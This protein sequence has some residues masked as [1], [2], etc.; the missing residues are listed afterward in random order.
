MHVVACCLMASA[1]LL[2]GCQLGPADRSP[3]GDA[4]PTPQ[5]GSVTPSDELS[6][7]PRTAPRPSASVTPSRSP[8]PPDDPPGSPAA[9][10]R[11]R[12]QS[13]LAT[14]RALAADIGPREATSPAYRR[15]AGLV[16]DRLRGLGYR[17][18]RQRLQ[19]PAGVSWG[20]PVRSGTTW[21]VVALP[22]AF[23]TEQPHLLLGAH[24]DTV[25]QAPGAEDNASGVAVLLEVARMAVRGDTRLP[26]VFV[27]F[28]AEEPRGEGDQLHHFGSQAYAG[29]MTVQ[30]RSALRGMVSLDRVGVGRVVPICTGG[31]S[32]PTVQNQLTRAARRV[33]VPVRRCDDNQSSDHWS[34]EKEGMLAARLGSTP[35]AA[36]HSAADVPGVVRRAQLARTGRITWEWLRSR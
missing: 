4:A 14:V 18:A 27:A 11:F 6:E 15:A 10:V 7:A 28:G 26:V 1:A 21:N 23:H 22:A 12:A 8:R 17:V 13:A 2:V 5:S 19:V 24:L 35:Y 36:Y 31:V 34:F 32:P 16:E 30:Q 29:R 20:V 33:D 3:D 9:P 25:P